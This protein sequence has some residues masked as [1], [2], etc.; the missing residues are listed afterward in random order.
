MKISRSQQTPALGAAIFSTVAAGKNAGG[1]DSVDEAK[2][3]MTGIDK[4]YMPIEENYEVYKKLYSLYRQLHDG[5][6]TKH[7][8]GCMFNVMKELLDLRDQA[9]KTN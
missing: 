7:W 4:E 9:R 5:F 2:K 3:A 6:G 8:S 1:Y